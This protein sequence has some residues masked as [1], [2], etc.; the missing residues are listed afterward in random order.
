MDEANKARLADLPAIKKQLL[1]RRKELEE[2][3]KQLY[4]EKFSDDQVQDV[5][6]QA[7]S[8]T[9]E[10]LKSSLQ[11]TKLDEYK[12]LSLALEMIEDG[13]YGKCVDCHTDIS[14]KRLKLFPNATRCLVCQELFEEQ[15]NPE[16][17]E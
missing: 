14:E 7:L 5:A 9:M 15:G 10:S 16:K 8:S 3:L 2:E 12:R 6:D 4:Q 1:Q 13:T 17:F 11:G